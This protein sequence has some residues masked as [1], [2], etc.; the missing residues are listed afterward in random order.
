MFVDELTVKLMAGSGGD[1]CTSFRREKFV[2]MGGPD[3]GNGGRGASIIMKVWISVKFG[4]IVL[5]IS[6]CRIVK[7][8]I[9]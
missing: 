1:G 5:M 9:I 4:D 6:F 3:G 8:M 7:L 2:P